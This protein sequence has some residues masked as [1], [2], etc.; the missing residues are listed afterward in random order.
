MSNFSQSQGNQEITRGRT[1]VHRTSDCADWRPAISG[2]KGH[3]WME[4]M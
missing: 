4:T 2:K 3:F 1:S